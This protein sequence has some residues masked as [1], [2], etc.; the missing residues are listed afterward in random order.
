MNKHGMIY[1]K[2]DGKN[3]LDPS[4][5]ID[6]EALCYKHHLSTSP[7]GGLFAMHAHNMYELLY[8][9]SGDATLVIEDRKYKLKN[10]DL[11]LIRPSK[12]HF[13]QIDSS[14]DYERYDVLFDEKTLGI[15]QTAMISKDTEVINLSGN[16]IADNIFRK[17]DYYFSKLDRNDFILVITLLLKELF[18]NL[19]INQAYF[20]TEYSIIHPL[21][22]DVLKY[23]N[24]NL[25]TIK[26]VREIANTL[27]VTESY[28]FRLFKSELKNSPKKYI[29]NKRLLYSQNLILMGGKP[30]E[31]YE[32]CGFNDY[33][34]FYRSYVKFF[35]HSPST[36]RKNSY[37]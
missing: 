8:F 16:T 32:D 23:I 18:F 2:K 15:S 26:S 24:S 13:I 12:Y 27:F 14:V 3:M 19:S 5:T 9:V 30:T 20:A 34:T 4:Y 33:T 6:T 10:G 31:I 1:F 17:F 36:D 28:I 11:I 7:L 25:F 21:L 35:G 22:S 37:S 29:T